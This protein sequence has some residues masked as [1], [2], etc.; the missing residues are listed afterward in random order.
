MI[1]IDTLT[2][3]FGGIKP[4]DDL[5][6][7]FVA[8]ICG[9]IGPNGAGKTTLL[10]VLSGFVRPT[11]GAI[12]LN[13]ALLLGLS[14]RRRVSLGLRRTFQQEL[15]VDELTAMENVQAIADHVSR[16]RAVARR[17]VGLALDFVGLSDR[18]NTLGRQLNLFERRMVEIAKTLIG[19]PTVILMDEPGA[20]L[21]ESETERLRRL[22]VEIPSKFNTQLVLIDHDADLIASV[23][24]ETLV[25]DF[26]KRL[27]MGPTRA[28]L[29]DPVVRRAYLGRE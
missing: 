18:R 29:N 16:D 9:L 12:L 22:L 11:K 24:I 2:V 3:Q 26:G 4:L 13:N 1:K 8:P 15:V 27:A 28:V 5:D 6:A 7:Q 23:C 19:R 10:N 25:L 17:E 20:G 21:N 14:P